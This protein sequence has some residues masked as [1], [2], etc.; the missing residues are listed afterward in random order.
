MFKNVPTEHFTILQDTTDMLKDKFGVAQ[1]HSSD[2]LRYIQ[3]D[4]GVVPKA[5]IITVAG[6]GGLVAG[7]RGCFFFGGGGKFINLDYL[8]RFK[9][10]NRQIK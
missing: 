10:G 8:V 9:I 1:A 4:A 7:Y 6:L 3:E 2:L 5:I